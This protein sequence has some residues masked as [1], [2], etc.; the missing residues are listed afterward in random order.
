MINTGQSQQSV[1][2]NLKT[3]EDDPAEFKA[4]QKQRMK[5]IEAE[6]YGD[7]KDEYMPP[8]MLNY[9]FTTQR[10]LDHYTRRPGDYPLNADSGCRG[11]W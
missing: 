5:K 8:P 3:Q 7:P 6:L 4:L 1:S 10:E 11:Y 2:L 9:A